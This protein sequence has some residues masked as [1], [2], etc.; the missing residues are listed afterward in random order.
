M[1]L[2][3][4]ATLYL[5]LLCRDWTVRLEVELCTEPRLSLGV[6]GITLGR[7]W[8]VTIELVEL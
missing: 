8:A 4:L 5:A 6:G 2:V 1:C 3:W 7:A